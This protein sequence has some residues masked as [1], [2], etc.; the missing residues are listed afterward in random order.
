MTTEGDVDKIGRAT[1]RGISWSV[2]GAVITNLVRL[3]SV[4]A[5]GRLLDARDFGVV[6]AATSILLV[7]HNVRD[8]GLGSA[9]VQRATLEPEHERTAFATAVYLG[10]ALGA[11]GRRV[12]TV[13]R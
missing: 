6:A 3:V 9:L 4:A 5:L 10:F 8:L 11:L 12:R 1:R 2:G 13:D 7:L